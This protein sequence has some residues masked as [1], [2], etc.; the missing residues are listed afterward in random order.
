MPLL[1][2]PKHTGKGHEAQLYTENYRQPR[3]AGNGRGGPL[4]GRAPQ[5]VV[6][7][8]TVSPGNIDTSNIIQ[9]KEVIFRNMCIYVYIAYDNN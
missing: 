8:P 6:Q 7:C 9:T 2:M 3:K 5:M 1:G 4:Q